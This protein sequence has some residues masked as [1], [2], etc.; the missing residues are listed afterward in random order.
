VFYGRTGHRE[1][2]ASNRRP[3]HSEQRST[4][5][6]PNQ[7]G[8]PAPSLQPCSPTALVKQ[9]LQKITQALFFGGRQAACLDLNRDIALRVLVPKANDLPL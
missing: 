7:K 8:Q 4:V 9:L 5:E 2:A 1:G 3:L 6:R